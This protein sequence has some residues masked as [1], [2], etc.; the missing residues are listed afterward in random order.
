[1]APIAGIVNPLLRAVPGKGS[2]VVHNFRD[3]AIIAHSDGVGYTIMYTRLS[4]AECRPTSAEWN[5]RANWSIW[6]VHTFDWINFDEPRRISPDG[7]ASPS[8][9]VTWH[10]QTV[11]ACQTYPGVSQL[12]YLVCGD[13]VPLPSSCWSD[14][15]PFLADANSLA[16]TNYVPGV[17]HI[18]YGENGRIIDPTLVVDPSSSTLHCF[19]IGTT[20]REGAVKHCNLLGHA[21]CI[22][23][24]MQDWTIQTNDCPLMGEDVHPEGV[25]NLSIVQEETGT[26]KMFLS[27]ALQKQFVAT[28]T[29]R[30]LHSWTAPEECHIL[31]T[32]PKKEEWLEAK[33][34]APSVW[35][36]VVDGK[37]QL[38]MLL[39]GEDLDGGTSIGIL[40]M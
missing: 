11:I 6:S 33:H 32:F 31:S 7:F 17:G 20:K 23:P 12:Y 28:S 14:P 5:N 27:V 10:G 36:A 15:K 39:M 29:S 1:M 24:K 2:G 37:R 38:Y 19:F 8:E 34:G 18:P 30:D 25:E 21:I 40:C 4:S 35:H 22:D 9:V 13:K 26:W 3:P 16:W